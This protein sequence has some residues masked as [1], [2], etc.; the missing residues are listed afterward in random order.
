MSTG[1]ELSREQVI[2]MN[3]KLRNDGFVVDVSFKRKGHYL[4][5]SPK[6]LGADIDNNEELNEFFKKH[7]K[8]SKVAFLDDDRVKDAENV[9]KAVHKK[10][11]NVSLGQSGVFMTREILDEFKVYLEEYKAKY[12]VERDKLCADYDTMVAFHKNEFKEKLV[13]NTMKSLSETE[14]D[15]LVEKAFKRVPTKDEYFNSFD[16]TISTTKVTLVGE[17]DESEEEDALRDTVQQV[18]EITGKN[19]AI[20]FEALNKLLKVYHQDGI[21]KSANKRIFTTVPNDLR[22]RNLFNDAII[23]EIIQVMSDFKSNGTSDVEIAEETEVYVSK[24]YGYAKE[25][26]VLESLNLL[27]AALTEDEM[28]DIYEIIYMDEGDSGIDLSA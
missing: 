24:I 17:L 5:V 26:D 1:V 16:V 22:K 8:A 9:S 28:L 2:E 23:E 20:A 12:F 13:K 6:L 19:L 7:V 21:L 18:N 14:R 10:K 3:K 15:E 25:L 4:T 11:R 27:D